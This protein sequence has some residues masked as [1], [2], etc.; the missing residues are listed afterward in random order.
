MIGPIELIGIVEM[1]GA[2]V[3]VR[4]RPQTAGPQV[5]TLARQIGALSRT[6]FA[7]E[8]TKLL[9][10]HHP[11]DAAIKK[12]ANRHPDKWM[13]MVS[14]AAKLAGYADKSESL[15]VHA[16]LSIQNMS[17]AELEI[18]LARSMALLGNII[19]PHTD[20]VIIA[21]ATETPEALADIAPA[22]LAPPADPAV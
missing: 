18:E 2:S 22:A 16:I 5:E 13:S 6:P 17:D 21:T 15:N 19:T 1:R 8:L 11:T 3:P 9:G 20:D 14:T 7:D 4:E 12:F 10:V